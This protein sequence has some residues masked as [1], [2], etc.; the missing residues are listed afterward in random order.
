VATSYVLTPAA[1]RECIT[2]LRKQRIH[3][4][5]PA[6]LHLR[7]RAAAEESLTNLHP[8][9]D[10]LSPFLQ[11][12]GAPSRK[13]HFRPFTQNAGGGGDEWLNPNL[14]GSYAPSSLRVGQAPLRVVE[15]GSDRGTFSLR[16][17]HWQLAREHLLN[18]ERIP[19]AALAGFMLRDFGF[20][21]DDDLPPAYPELEAAFAETFGYTDSSADTELD[22]LYD[23]E[24]ITDA[25]WFEP[26]AQGATT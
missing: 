10:D 6:Y 15:F 20:E 7:Q 25:W 14:A 18:D 13:P 5:F 8:S 12:R 1:V 19:L 23:R 21:M 9:W 22:Y 17:N 24:P 11:V 2:L 3:P 26:L 4:Y 16:P